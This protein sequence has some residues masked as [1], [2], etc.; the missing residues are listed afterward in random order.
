MHRT[1][2]WYKAKQQV[3][4]SIMKSFLVF[5]AVRK[6]RKVDIHIDLGLHNRN[7]R[8]TKLP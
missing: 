6:Q 2:V 5:S 4:L 1:R 7:A 8:E 3:K